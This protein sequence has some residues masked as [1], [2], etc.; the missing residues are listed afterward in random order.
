MDDAD[1]LTGVWTG[2]F[3]MPPGMPPV[4][5]TATMVQSGSHLSG[6]THEPCSIAECSIKDHVAMLSGVRAGRAVSF[7]KTYDPPGFG[8]GTV[9][10]DGVLNGDATEI[11]GEWTLQPGLTGQFLMIREGRKTKARA[12]RKAATV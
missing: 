11:S 10:Y 2:S 3:S 1:N 7:T 4:T 12:R 9:K 6:T 8:Y 5:F